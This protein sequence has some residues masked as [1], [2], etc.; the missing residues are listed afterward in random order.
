[1]QEIYEEWDDAV[2]QQQWRLADEVMFMTA[3][4]DSIGWTRF[5]WH[6]RYSD[7]DLTDSDENH[8]DR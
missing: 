3:C 2:L 5:D 8:S 7:W 1:M 4:I 6:S